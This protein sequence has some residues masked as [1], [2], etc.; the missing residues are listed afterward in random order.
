MKRKI[1]LIL[2]VV[3]LFSG[4]TVQNEEKE[5]IKEET[6]VSA[7]WIF[8]N[9]LNMIN[10]GGGNES[11]FR[12]KVSKMFD[13][14]VSWGINTVF[15]QVRPCAD[16]FY[17]SSIFPWSYYLT[18]EQGKA[19][20][21]DPLKISIEEAHKRK[22]T[23]HAWIN[24]FRIAFGDDISKLS[25]NHPAMKW[26]Q[27]KKADVVFVNGGIY[28][29]PAS[30]EAQ[31]LVIDGVREIIRNYDVDGIHIDDYFYPSVDAKVDS[32]F[33]KKYTESGGELS[34]DDWRLN[35]ISAFVS[36][37]YS[38]VK[39]E[40]EECI[41]SVSPAGNINN[42]YNEQYADVKLWCSQ[43][44]YADWIIPQ[45]YYGFE[46]DILPFDTALEKWSEIHTNG[47]IK[48]IYG[49]AA[50]KVNDSDSEWTAGKGIIDK[51]LKQI[52]DIGAYGVAFFSYS[53]LADEKRSAEFKNLSTVLA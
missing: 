44:G 7:V 29:S 1:S 31:K 19:V 22:L 41:F 37:L 15:L 35:M 34:L 24:P 49:V 42:N 2:F 14:C 16:S 36:Q 10:E 11:L 26:I 38:A 6:G 50:Y 39:A 53:S 17:N 13:D 23:L 33:Y 45:I 52:K 47:D 48:M 27:K 40:N 46:N 20:N 18:G 12:D 8:Y 5:S 3:M 25:D 43:T 4:C 28:F 21:Y 32:E 9:E 51:Q 30:L